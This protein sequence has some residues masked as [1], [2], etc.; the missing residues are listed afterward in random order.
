MCPVSE[1]FTG[2]AFVC[3]EK[4]VN[5]CDVQTCPVS[6]ARSF[7]CRSVR[8]CS[9]LLRWDAG[10]TDEVV[11]HHFPDLCWW[12]E[13]SVCCVMVCQIHWSRTRLDF[14]VEM[15]VV[16]AMSMLTSADGVWWRWFLAKTTD[17]SI[18][19]LLLLCN[20]KDVRQLQCALFARNEAAKTC[21][22]ADLLIL[23]CG[24]RS[25]ARHAVLSLVSYAFED[26]I[27]A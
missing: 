2:A 11:V 18:A 24:T 9:L 1:E 19:S 27:P 21:T 13:E 7:G 20:F 6:W 17:S 26:I 8:G 5:P 12:E 4:G 15:S 25:A 14:E 16:S 23:F 22:V 10:M 3:R